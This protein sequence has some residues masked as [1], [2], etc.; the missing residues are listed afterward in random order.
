[1]HLPYRLPVLL[2]LSL[3]L[4]AGP[5]AARQGEPPLSLTQGAKLGFELP[6]IEA[7][8]IDAAV[9]QREATVA[10]ATTTFQTKRLKV[11]A[12]LAVSIAPDTDG[13]LDR[14]ADGRTVWRSRVRVQGATDLRLAFGHFDLPAGARFY[15]IGADDYYQ[16]PYT[17]DDG[18]DGT[19]TAPVVPGD[20]ATLELQ[21][22]AGAPADANLLLL[23]GIGAGFRDLFGREKIGSP[24]NSG[25]CNVNVACP[26]GQPYAREASSVA[27]LEFRNDEDSQWYRCT[28]TLLADVPRSRRNWFLTA[29]HCVDS[30]AEAASATLYWNYQSTSCNSTTPPPGG[31]FNDNQSGAWLRAARDDVDFSLMELKSAPLASWSVFRAG[32]DANDSAPPGTI[33]LHHPAGDVKK[34]TAGPVPRT[35][36]NCT[37]ARPAPGTHWQT[38]PYTQGTTE[39]GSSGSGIFVPA[40]AGDRGHRLVG[41]L[42]GGNAGCSSV[43]PTQPNSGTDC[44][45]KF[46]IA[47][48]GPSADQRLRDWLDPAGTGTRS[49]AGGDEMPPA[50]P[51]L[52]GRVP[53]EPPPLL[54]KLPHRR[55]AHP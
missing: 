34:V 5:A 3:M 30:A 32:W 40:S 14:L 49:I 15:V 31:Y 23:D 42:S 24:G 41:F 20:M 50:E 55:A 53:L 7:G 6:V 27:Y 43:S 54:R 52:E 44:Y 51:V 35:T 36:G 16:G 2:I 29:A 26:L 47:W 11:A 8:A 39:G 48:D 4:A 37:L 46:A 9:L 25:A 10:G 12:G 33:G 22:P 13:R 21:L 45:G 19:F 1:M 17:G 18:F 38:G 28:G